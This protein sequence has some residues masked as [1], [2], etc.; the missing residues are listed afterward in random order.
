MRD[1]LAVNV[2]RYI[3]TN[4]LGW[5]FAIVH[6]VVVAFAV[7]GDQPD[8]PLFAV[9]SGTQLMYILAVLNLPSTLILM[10]IL[11]IISV[12]LSPGIGIA[13]FAVALAIILVTLQWMIVGAASKV[14][15]DGHKSSTSSDADLL[16]LNLKP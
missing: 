7:L 10:G 6:W 9:D 14:L 11:A 1:N 12:I 2:I 8:A 16:D 13:V 5:A 4:P 15:Y 3:L